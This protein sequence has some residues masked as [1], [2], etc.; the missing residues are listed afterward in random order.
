MHNRVQNTVRNTVQIKY[1]KQSMNIIKNI[2]IVA[3]IIFALGIT[4]MVME[5]NGTEILMLFVLYIGGGLSV[6]CYAA[7]VA[8]CLYIKRL[9]GYG[10][11]IPEK[12]SDYDGKVEN[13]PKLDHVE[14][15]SIYS[16]HS[17]WGSR[18]CLLMFIIF[19]V[20]DV[21]Y[22]Q[23]WKFMKDN[24]KSFFVLCFLFY[25][26][27]VLFALVLK[28]QSNKNKY[29][30]DVEPDVARKIRWSLEEILFTMV[31]LCLLSIFANSTAYSVT[32]YI[33]NTMID[34][35][36]EQAN[37]VCRATIM[38]ITECSDKNGTAACKET[39][40]ALCEGVDITTWGKPKDALQVKIAEG[41]YVEDFSLMC[42]DFKL[43]DGDA[44]IFV[45]I[46]DEKVTVRLLNA[47]K[48]LE[49]YSKKNKEIYVENKK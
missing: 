1:D 8:G 14:E 43:S 22:Y 34:Y 42:D 48:E 46:D 18:A 40:D 21:I 38:A 7:L 5:I 11:K 49:L 37:I 3:T 30:D 33:F 29:R 20:L 28:K 12:K 36:M 23:Q 44:Q 10:Y 27:W 9:K 6:G 4:L 39:Y 26:I 13:L 41:L 19:V 24:S 47:V 25:L 35:D 15:T 31:I 45:K 16:K 32:R 2:A 17:K